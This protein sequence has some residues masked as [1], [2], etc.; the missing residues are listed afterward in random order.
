VSS[1]LDYFPISCKPRSH[2]RLGHCYIHWPDYNSGY[3]NFLCSLILGTI[4]TGQLDLVN[5]WGGGGMQSYCGL[6]LRI[7]GDPFCFLRNV[8]RNVWLQ[9]KALRMGR[10]RVA[11]RVV[12]PTQESEHMFLE[13]KTRRTSTFYFLE[14]DRYG[15]IF[16]RLD[17]VAA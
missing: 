2:G 16:P 4:N 12:P 15:T 17:S 1:L 10:R 13:P 11:Y 3:Y 6:A 9:S 5:A 7:S 14:S 8:V